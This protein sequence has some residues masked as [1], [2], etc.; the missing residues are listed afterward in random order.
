M[1]QLSSSLTG[2]FGPYTQA[3]GIREVRKWITQIPPGDSICL[4]CE[5][6]LPDKQ[7]KVWQR[8]FKTHEDPSWQ[9][10]KK[11]KSFFYYKPRE[12]E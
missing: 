4:R 11:H 8:W 5:S 2:K 9:I 3:I 12:L 10:N 6:V 7:F 1:S